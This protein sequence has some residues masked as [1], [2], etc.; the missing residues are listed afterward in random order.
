MP[1]EDRPPRLAVVAA[2]IEDDGGRCVE[3][4]ARL[5]TRFR[6]AAEAGAAAMATPAERA[7]AWAL[8]GGDDRGDEL[9]DQPVMA[10]LLLL[11]GDVGDTRELASG[12]NDAFVRGDGP[13]QAAPRED[14]ASAFADLYRSLTL[15]QLNSQIRNKA[16]EIL[17]RLHRN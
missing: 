7:L 4:V 2:M 14:R 3:S 15:H 1:S 8:Q 12:L 6:T 10:Q 11:A 16:A 13:G 9:A 17:G 5:G